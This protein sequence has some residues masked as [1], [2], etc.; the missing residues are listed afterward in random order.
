M[1]AGFG[2]HMGAHR[3][4][5]RLY[6]ADGFYDDDGVYDDDGLDCSNLDYARLH[7]ECS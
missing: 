7:P 5:D 2:R 6:G 3:H 4:G 1:D